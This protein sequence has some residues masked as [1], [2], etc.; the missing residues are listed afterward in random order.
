MGTVEPIRLKSD[1]RKI[2]AVLAK[3]SERCYLT[4]RWIIYG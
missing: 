4:S 3:Q 2:E 1:I